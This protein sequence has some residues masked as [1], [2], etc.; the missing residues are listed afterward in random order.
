MEEELSIVLLADEDIKGGFCNV[1][2]HGYATMKRAFDR[3]NIKN[4]W[5]EDAKGK[6]VKKFATIG[7]NTTAIDAWDNILSSNHPHLMFSVDSCFYQNFHI[8]NQYINNPNFHIG[9]ITKSDLEPLKYFYPD[10]KNYYFIPNAVDKDIWEYKNQEKDLDIVYVASIHEPEKIIEETRAKLPAPLFDDFMSLFEYLKQNPHADIWEI[11]KEAFINSLPADIEKSQHA[12]VFHYFYNQITYLTSY[13][14]RIELVKSFDSIGVKV[15]G[16]PEWEKY[17]TGKNEYMGLLDY[18][19]SLDVIPRAKVALNL[20]PL[21]VIGGI[22]ERIL[23]S[24]LAECA[25]LSD[26]TPEIKST[27]G[28]SLSYFDVKNFTNIKQKAL[29]LLAN[30]ELRDYKI[31]KAKEIVLKDHTWDSAA[32]KIG[33][34]V[35][36]I[37][38]DQAK[39]L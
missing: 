37:N 39:I 16:T 18:K 10:F 32:Q 25:V 8:I 23:T 1:L 3:Q 31:Q 30:K 14:K 11:Y 28:E 13:T 4:Y 26:A 20:Q 35:E 2:G 36:Q 24:S 38:Q 9:L 15:W 5:L 19:D 12:Y 34:I 27:F 22:H 17:I 29:S 33:A 6:R 21:Q 7:F